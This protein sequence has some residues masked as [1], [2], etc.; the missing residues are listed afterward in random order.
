MAD[1]RARLL[2]LKAQKAQLALEAQEKAKEA[3][4]LD[5]EF[6][7]AKEDFEA[8]KERGPAALRETEL[9]RFK[10]K[11][12]EL[13]QQNERLQQLLKDTLSK[14]PGSKAAHSHAQA[15]SSSK[16]PAPS[17]RASSSKS[18][19]R[20]PSA[21]RARP[22]TAATSVSVPMAD[23]KRVGGGYDVCDYA[24]PSSPAK[25]QV[26]RSGSPS[27]AT[28]SLADARLRKQLQELQAEEAALKEKL[29]VSAARPSGTPTLGPSSAD[30]MFKNELRFEL[31]SKDREIGYNE[32]RCDDAQRTLEKAREK[33]SQPLC[34]LCQTW[35]N[36][37]LPSA[38]HCQRRI[39]STHEPLARLRQRPEQ[40]H[41]PAR[42]RAHS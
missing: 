10:D 26:A 42:H 1:L 34:A 5:K 7:F 23:L 33:V 13:K 39:R 2:D 37:I 11:E 12:R 36:L 19:D 38:S 40:T 32:K 22:A 17:V 35:S 30:S 31:Q 3:Q 4:Q 9:N 8:V 28:E 18:T 27:S 25:S 15:K 29:S 16:T 14:A 20:P 41:C 21:V 24:R 6:K